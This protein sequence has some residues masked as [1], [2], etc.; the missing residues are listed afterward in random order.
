MLLNFYLL[1]FFPFLALCF[2]TC[3][4]IILALCNQSHYLLLCFAVHFNL[5]VS[6]SCPQVYFGS[7]KK[8]LNATLPCLSAFNMFFCNLAR[9]LFLF[10]PLWF[11]DNE[12]HYLLVW[13]QMWHKKELKLYI[14]ILPLKKKSIL[15][16]DYSVDKTFAEFRI[17]TSR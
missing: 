5:F 1:T 17:L 8:M 9:F 16:C 3:F 2:S 13:P 12:Y 11:S 4:C 6:S 10:F 15:H 14:A 7:F